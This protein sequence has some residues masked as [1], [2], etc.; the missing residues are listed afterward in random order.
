[1]QEHNKVGDGDVLQDNRE[2]T[3]T[4]VQQLWNRQMKW[5]NVKHSITWERADERYAGLLQRHRD[6]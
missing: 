5:A 6:R 2:G 4:N 3:R 1:M